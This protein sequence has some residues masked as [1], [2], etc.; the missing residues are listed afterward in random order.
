M[1]VYSVDAEG[2]QSEREGC[3][4]QKAESIT[5][6]VHVSTTRLLGHTITYILKG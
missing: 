1:I 4:M 6:M 5:Y 2:E 3:D